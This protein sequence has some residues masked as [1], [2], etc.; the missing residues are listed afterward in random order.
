MQREDELVEQGYQVPTADDLSK[1]KLWDES[2]VRFATRKEL[3]ELAAQY[4]ELE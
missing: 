2:E 4:L 1:L 3:L